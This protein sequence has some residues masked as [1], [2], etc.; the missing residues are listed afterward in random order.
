MPALETIVV[1]IATRVVEPD[2][3]FFIV[4]PGQ[5]ASLYDEFYKRSAVFLDFPDLDLVAFGAARPQSTLRRE[6]ALRSLA[7]RDYHNQV[8]RQKRKS[9]APN[10]VPLPSRNIADYKGKAFRARLGTYISAIEKLYSQLPDGTIIIVPPANPYKQVLI[11]V[12]DG[13][14][15]T[16]SNFDLY[17]GENLPG[18]RVRWLGQRQQAAFTPAARKVL[19]NPQPL[20]QLDRKLRDEFLRPAF[21]QFIIG[22]EFTARFRTEADD[23]SS[24]D[25][26]DITSFVNYIAGLIAYAEEKGV[27]H[28]VSATE[29]HALLRELRDRVP[30]L[31]VNINSPGFLRLLNK[32]VDPVTIAAFMTMAIHGITPAVGQPIEV[33]NSVGAKHDA[34]SLTVSQQAK[35]VMS[36]MDFDELASNCKRLDAAAK[37]VHLKSS[38]KVEKKK[39]KP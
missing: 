24:L 17:P 1:D 26:E 7:I 36:I 33:I 19:E 10:N 25:S 13:P 15:Q 2:E 21:D 14:A 12:L 38:M 4:R 9:Q 16:F 30:E 27:G 6:I 18:R 29:A 3:D 22:E 8:R 39:L 23:F 31:N 28:Q 37:N 34:C 35:G 11:G 32:C 5:G 20:M